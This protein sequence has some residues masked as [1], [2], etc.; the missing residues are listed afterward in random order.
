MD[1]SL[2]KNALQFLFGLLAI[3]SAF[4]RT[5]FAQESTRLGLLPAIITTPL[6]PPGLASFDSLF[7]PHVAALQ[8]G[9]LA[10]LRSENSLTLVRA[11]SLPWHAL[12]AFNAEDVRRFGHKFQ[13]A[14]LLVPVL[15]ISSHTPAEIMR[16]RV[17]LRWLDAASGEMT[18]F[19]VVDF[20]CAARDTALSGFEARA[21]LSALMEAPELIFAQEQQVAMLPALRE[22]PPP[23][24]ARPQTRRWLYY[25]SAAALLSGG[26]AYLLLHGGH[27][28]PTKRLLPEPPG[29]P[30]Q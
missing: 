24:V 17:L 15:E 8:R 9:L 27:D 25:V 18:K 21:A 16:G 20:E 5:A 6:S 28:S 3:V 26:S 1:G 23:V 30:P 14:K 29:P 2:K 10:A 13:L 12:D 22:L 11:D 4:A 19:H 7:A